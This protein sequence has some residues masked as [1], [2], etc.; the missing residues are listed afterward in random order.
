MGK[1]FDISLILLLAFG[2]FRLGHYVGSADGYYMGVVS[3]VDLFYKVQYEKLLD[4]L[5]HVP[6]CK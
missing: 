4:S 2:L 5:S 3:G 6:A 1:I